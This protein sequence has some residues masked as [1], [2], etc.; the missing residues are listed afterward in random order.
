MWKNKINW[1]GSA[2]FYEIILRPDAIFFK[3]ATLSLMS[4]TLDSLEFYS[5][6]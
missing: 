6:T 5:Y 2:R 4:E 3:I 1:K